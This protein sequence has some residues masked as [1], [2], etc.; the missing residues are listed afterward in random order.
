MN[1]LE[2]LKKKLDSAAERINAPSFISSDPVQFPRRMHTLRDIE[3][4]ALLTA[5]IAWGRR[6]SIIA[7]GE[8]L[9]RLMQGSPYHFVAEGAFEDL[10]DSL[11]VHRTFFVRNLKNWC[12]TLRHIYAHNHT[13][14]SFA[15]KNG[16]G[17]SEEPAWH[18]ARLLLSQMSEACGTPDPRCLPTDLNATALKRINMA[19]RWLVR[20][21]GIVDLGTWNSIRPSQ[22]FIP[23]DVHVGNT[24]RALGLTE[25]KANDKRTV[26]DITLKLRQMRPDDPVFYDYALFGLGMGL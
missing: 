14:D 21:D 24:A 7:D 17:E 4:T 15:A 12:R 19:L 8:K 25:R 26:I 6:S 13:V 1:D 23:L 10:P 22:L 20:C 2:T 5:T 3:T 9:M 18:L 11:N 16:V